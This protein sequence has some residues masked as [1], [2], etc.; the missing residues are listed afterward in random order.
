MLLFRGIAYLVSRIYE[1][2]V[3]D[4]ATYFAHAAYP[5]H[6]LGSSSISLTRIMVV[7]LSSLMLARVI[8]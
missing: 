7:C 1:A 6:Q 5:M 2:V 4:P 3:A 8:A